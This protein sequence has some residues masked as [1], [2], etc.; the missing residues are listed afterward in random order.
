MT[1]KNKTEFLRGLRD[2]MPIGAGYFAVSFALGI[3]AASAGMSAFSAALMSFLNVTSAGEAAAITLI[4]AGTTVAELVLTQLI[5]NARYFLMSC[6][7]SQKLAG[8]VPLY[9]RFAVAFGVT[10]EIFGICSTVHGKLDPMYSYGAMA[11]A[12]PAWTLGTALGVV[13]GSALP[14]AIVSALGLALYGMFVAIIIPG[15]KR[16]R[17]VAMLITVSMALSA[18]FA[19]IPVLSGVSQGFRIIIITVLCSAGAAAAAPRTEDDGE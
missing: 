9:H 17:A 3:S 2:G 8:D 13:F 18:A 1:Q 15:A 10:D 14:K 5:I 7:L 4:K 16:S 12:L 11:I 6:S 19:Y